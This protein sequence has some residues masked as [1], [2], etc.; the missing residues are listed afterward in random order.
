MSEKPSLYIEVDTMY[1][2]NEEAAEG[3]E[4]LYTYVIS[5]PEDRGQ[6]WHVMK[7]KEG[8]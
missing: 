5:Y 8:V 1:K 4:L 6:E 3:Y 2:V 7:L